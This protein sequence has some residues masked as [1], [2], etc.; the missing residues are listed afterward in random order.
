MT[1]SDQDKEA[2]ELVLGAIMLEPNECL[3]IFNLLRPEH[4]TQRSNEIIYT[5]CLNL[6]KLGAK[7]DMFTVTQ[8]VIKQGQLAEINEGAYY[9]ST[10]LNRVVTGANAEDHAKFIVEGYLKRQMW[11]IGHKIVSKALSKTTDIF[12]TISEFNAAINDLT[13]NLTQSKE[14][15]IDEVAKA[16]IEGLK[17]AVINGSPAGVLTEITA[18]NNWTNGWQRS[19]LIILAARPGMGKTAAAVS[20][21]LSASMNGIPVCFYSMEMSAEQ[22]TGRVIS[23]VSSIN[24]Q[25]VVSKKIDQVQLS[26]IT[27]TVKCLDGIPFYIDD[28]AGITIHKLRTKAIQMKRKY[29][30]EMIIVDYL[31]LMSGS[32]GNREQE[33]SEISRGLKLL[34]KELNIPVIALSQLSREV[35]K[36]PNKKPLLSD[37]RESGSI[38][39]DADMVIFLFRPSY[40]DFDVYETESERITGKELEQLL[41]IDIAKFRHGGLGEIKA[42]F[43]PELTAI[44]NFR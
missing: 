40:Y 4:F 13:Q 20:F 9:I 37:L 6:N 2:E 19:D 17:D 31:Q 44:S 43:I 39:Q 36:R 7:I 34:A 11:Q 21:A 41:I 35:E 27:N 12:T 10:L 24:S 33:I 23:Q 18:L 30:L 22:L 38:E 8:Q 29:G 15:R 26:Q 42:R 16:V 3:E 25:R 14:K 32:K 5:A 28:Q 1:V